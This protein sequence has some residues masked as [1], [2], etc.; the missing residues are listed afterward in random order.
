MKEKIIATILFLSF[1]L[2]SGYYLLFQNRPFVLNIISPNIIQV[3]LNGNHIPDKNET[4]C[5]EDIETFTAKIS[6]ENEELAKRIGISNEYAIKIGYLTDSE[7]SSLLAGQFVKVKL[8]KKKSPKCQFGK[9]YIENSDYADILYDNGFAIKNSENY[10]QKAF[11]KLLAKA[12]K[13]ELVILN[14]KNLKYHT[15]NC[16]Y[17]KMAKEAIIIKKNELPTSSSPCKFCHNGKKNSKL[18]AGINAIKPPQNAISDGNL[19]LILTDFTTILKPDRHC[20]HQ[21]CKSFVELINSS[22]NSIDIALYGWANIPKVDDAIN[23]AIA[24]GVK[25]RL[26]YD[27]AI[28]KPSYYTETENFVSRFTDRKSDEIPQNKKL[29]NMLMHNKFAIFDNQKVFTGSMNYS[30][31]GFSGFNH[32][33]ILIINSAQI[34]DLYKNEFNQMY[35]GNFHTQKEITR[36]NKNLKIANSDISVF[37]SP[38][39]KGLS[40]DIIPII[41]NAKKYIYIPTF[42]LTHKELTLTQPVQELHT[43]NL[44][45]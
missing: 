26:V 25:I 7:A 41:K 32:N 28:N 42:I 45:N 44:K 37:F 16:K 9:I 29:T 12:Q 34:A 40:K 10:N 5:V 33:S 24:R 8:S 20:N 19:T 4:I 17:G 35:G 1:L 11:E 43:Q 31:T 6:T 27:T 3:D 39:D 14:K 38:Q 18:T 30:T 23:K 22:Q 15:L 21:A 13:L 36:N 2:F